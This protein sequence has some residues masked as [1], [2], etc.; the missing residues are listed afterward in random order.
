M[1]EQFIQFLWKFGLFDK[2]DM[3]TTTGESIEVLSLGVHNTDAGPD[4]SNARLKIG[5]VV[6]A[7]NVEVHRSA[8]DWNRHCH[9]CNEAYNNVILHVV[10]HNDCTIQSHNGASVAVYEIQ[11]DTRFEQRYLQLMNDKK[12]VP[13]QHILPQIE[14]FHWQSFLTRLA[15]E[16]LEQRA[17]HIADLLA[18]NKNDWEATFL[19][20][21]FRAFGFGINAD[22]LEQ[23]AQSISP[24][25]I[26]KHKNSLLQ[27]EALLFGQAG[28]LDEL[29]HD[30]YQHKLQQEYNLLKIKFLLAPLPKHVWKFLRIRPVNFPTVRIAQLASLLHSTQSLFTQSIAATTLA[31]ALKLFAADTSEY[32]HTHYS[33]DTVSPDRSKPLGKKSAE[34][35]VANVLIPTMFHYGQVR[36]DEQL[37]NRAISLLEQLPPEENAKTA[38]WERLQLPPGNMLESQALLQLTNEYCNKHQCLRCVVGRQVISDFRC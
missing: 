2:Q 21:L 4:F 34:R 16:R 12:D 33:F 25:C 35:L 23:L 9:Q 6:W 36:N 3:R 30:E 31:D 8:S 10:Q 32:W 20:L 17:Q 7:G 29:P 38:I 15:C 5:N 19:Q 26:A 13:C 24:A 14:H 1:D 11:Y 18:T 27:L 37:C 28:F 22:P